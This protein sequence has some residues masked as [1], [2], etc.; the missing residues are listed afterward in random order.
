MDGNF[1]RLQYR[2]YVSTNRAI[3]AELRVFELVKLF[4][5]ATREYQYQIHIGDVDLFIPE[6][7]ADIDEKSSF[8]E[9]RWCDYVTGEVRVHVVK[10]AK[11]HH[12]IVEEPYVQNLTEQLNDCLKS[13]QEK[14]VD[15]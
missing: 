11:T 2:W 7:K 15:K 1:K 8:L 13:S 9:R 5:L 4:E 14:I 10:G 6:G 3:P 12:E